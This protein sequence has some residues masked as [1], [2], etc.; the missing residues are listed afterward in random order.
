MST[1][2]TVVIHLSKKKLVLLAVG[3]TV[4]VALGIVLLFVAKQLAGFEALLVQAVGW[5]CII[6]FG[7]ALVVALRKLADNRPGLVISDVGIEDNSSGVAA[8]LIP[9]IEIQGLDVSMVQS[10]QFLTIRVI[11]P[12]KY[13]ERGNFIKRLASRANLKYYGSPIQISASALQLDF[14][15]LVA[16]VKQ[17]FEKHGVS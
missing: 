14:E 8:G 2:N 16:L 10:Q 5:V 13:L 6:F 11:N 17:R 1:E 15:E 9:W 12:E 7:L 3:A 4:F